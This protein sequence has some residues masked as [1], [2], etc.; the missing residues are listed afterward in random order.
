MALDMNELREIV[1]NRGFDQLVGEIEGQFF[2]AKG[3]PYEFDRMDAKREF[4]KDVAAFANAGGGYILIGL[5]TKRA[6]KRNAEEVSATTPFNHGLFDSDRHWK[7]LSE[8][9]YP[10]PSGLTIDWVEFGQDAEKGLGVI[11]V[12]PQDEWSKPFLLTRAIE[13]NKST[14]LLI[15]YVERHL[16]RTNVRKIAEIHQ[17]L[18]TGLNLE[19]E[20]LGRIANIE[21]LVERHFSAK[22]EAE[23]AEKREQLLNERIARLLEDAN[24]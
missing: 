24:G 23:S 6:A 19:R 22:A 10:Q 14:E 18:R 13:D 4:A 21:L 3:R 17:A 8:W 1:A 2:D 15:G 7:I 5:D 9:L 16:D 20:L 12:S 11:F